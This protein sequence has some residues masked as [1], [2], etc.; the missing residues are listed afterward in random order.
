MLK[1]SKL[2]LVDGSETE[3]YWC[4]ECGNILGLRYTSMNPSW[5]FCPF[6]GM[7]INLRLAKY[8]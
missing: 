4:D 2:V 8:V 5:N 1:Y 7:V 3:Q 6:C